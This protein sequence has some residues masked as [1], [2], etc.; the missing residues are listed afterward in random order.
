[1]PMALELNPQN[2][3]SIDPLLIISPFFKEGG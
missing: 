1:M 2:A 3:Q